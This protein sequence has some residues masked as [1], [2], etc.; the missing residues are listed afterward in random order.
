MKKN[1]LSTP[2]Q[3]L[4]KKIRR[5]P[6]NGE[7]DALSREF[8][9]AFPEPCF[10]LK[11]DG[12]VLVANTLVQSLLLQKEGDFLQQP[13]YNR[14]PKDLRSKVEEAVAVCLHRG[15]LQTVETQLLTNGG[16]E[17][18]VELFLSRF[19]PRK[20]GKEKYCVIVARDIIEKKQKEL[21]LLRFSNVVHYTVNPIEITDINGKIVYVNPA[22]EK[23]CGYR[24][25]ELYGKNPNVFS[26]GK[27]TPGF[28]KRVWETILAGKVWMGEIE[29][30]RKTGEPFFAQLLISPILDS[31][32]Q[33]VGFLGVHHD[34]TDQ[35]FLEQQLVHAQKMES[36][37]T[38][39]AGVAHEVGNPLTSISSLVQI[40]QR[41][42]QEDFTK[43]KLDMV[44]SQITR[45]S[46]IL[47]DLVDFSRRSTYEVQMTDINKGVRESIE[48]VR[49]GKKAKGINL[50]TNLDENLP[51]LALVPDQLLQVFINILINAADAINTKKDT[52]LSSGD[53]KD[54]ITVV[55]RTNGQIVQI[56]IQ[57]SGRGISQEHLDKI[58]EPF[59][60]TKKIGEGTGLGLWVSYGIIKSFQGEITVKSKEGKGTTFTISLPIQQ[61]KIS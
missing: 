2:A 52:L 26:S 38:L 51:R 60:T 1:N 43:E 12:T 40:I 14:I 25:E 56:L 54:E 49:V 28:W 5:V 37:G 3:L 30:R 33:I 45:I 39:A 4:S 17:M 6:S 24:K 20:R 61:E 36:I 11:S 44:K 47:R 59:F 7:N 16:F 27:Y 35:K 31:E 13:L 34:I 18:D 21:D 57:D 48:I 46:R 9:N 42:T 53:S 32:E 58:F 41:T 29:N 15:D 8:L 23:A 55:T 19:S 10:V 50:R 22:F